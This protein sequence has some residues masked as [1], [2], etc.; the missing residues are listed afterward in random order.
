ME[1]NLQFIRLLKT[2]CINVIVQMSIIAD[3]NS[4]FKHNSTDMKVEIYW[5]LVIGAF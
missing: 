4:Q 1:W 3:W 5:L 2:R